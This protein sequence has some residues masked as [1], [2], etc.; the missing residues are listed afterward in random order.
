MIRRQKTG[1]WLINDSREGY[2]NA[3]SDTKNQKRFRQKKPLA[4]KPMAFFICE[5][6]FKKYLTFTTRFVIIQTISYD[7]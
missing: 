2:F 4:K 6:Y 5:K 3:G 7:M 1:K